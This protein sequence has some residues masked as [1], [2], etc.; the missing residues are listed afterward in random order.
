[1]NLEEINRILMSVQQQCRSVLTEIESKQILQSIGIPVSPYYMAVSSAEAVHYAQ[2]IGY[3]VVLKIVS[4]DISHKTDAKGV[5]L[6]L[7]NEREVE[8]AYKEIMHNACQYKAD[9]Q[10]VGVSVQKMAKKGTEVII[11]T[12]RDPVF[13]PVLLFGMGGIFVEVLEDV[14]LKTLPVADEDIDNMFKEIKLSPLLRGYRENP[15]ADLDFVKDIIFKLAKFCEHYPQVKEMEINPL[16]VYP[17][18]EGACAVDARMF[19][20]N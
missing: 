17:S 3:P 12:K 1:M 10:I 13:G 15:P 5:M 7:K 16:F 4:P 9:A 18:G 19:V 8:Q 11:G 2:K 6:N 20:D 14:T